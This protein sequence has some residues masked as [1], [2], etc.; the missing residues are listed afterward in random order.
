MSWGVKARSRSSGGHPVIEAQ[1]AADRVY[2][3][4]PVD[5]VANGRRKRWRPKPGIDA[6][7]FDPVD[8]L[9]D[10]VLGRSPRRR[11]GGR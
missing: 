6:V 3:L 9:L 5:A 11:G 7:D 8:V 10:H 1:Q 2:T 4:R